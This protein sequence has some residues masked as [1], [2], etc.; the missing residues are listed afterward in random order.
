M[1]INELISDF[2]IYISNEEATL[3]TRLQQTQPLDIFSERE[4]YIIETM[5]RKS[6]VTKIIKNNQIL[7]VSNERSQD[8]S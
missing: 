3:L 7:V 1:K 8:H 6:I 5:I 2:E 4:Q